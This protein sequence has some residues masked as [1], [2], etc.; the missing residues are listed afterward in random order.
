[1]R[2]GEIQRFLLVFALI[3]CASLPGS[4]QTQP[5]TSGNAAA[6]ANAQLLRK[7]LTNA[8]TAGTPLPTAT[9]VTDNLNIEAVMLPKS[10]SEHVFGKTVADH[11]AVI[12]VNIA[13]RSD[14]ASFVLQSLYIDYSKW[15]LGNLNQANPAGD[16]GHPYCK[17]STTTQ[18]SSVE[19]RI[20]R[21]QM[22]DRQPWSRRNVTS[23]AI[24]VL[25]SIGTAFAFPFTTDVVRGIGAWN[26]AV[27][28]GFDTLFPDGTQAHMDRVSDYGFRDNKVIPQQSADIVIAF[29][30]IDRF[31]TPTLRNIFLNSPALFFSPMLLALDPQS[32]KDVLKIM[33]MAFPK[34]ANR[35]TEKNLQNL[36][37]KIAALDPEAISADQDKVNKATAAFVQLQQTV[38]GDERSI[39]QSRD[40]AQLKDLTDKKSADETALNQAEK[41]MNDADQALSKDFS[42][43]ESDPVYRFLE[44]MSLNNISI[45]VSGIMSVDQ[46]IIPATINSTCF[47]KAGAELWGKKQEKKAC[48]IKG[49]YL[50][51]GTPQIANGSNLGITNLTV[52]KT[53][54][55]AELLNFT[56]DLKAPLT[57]GDFD[58]VVAKT[59]KNGTE[60]DS[61]KYHVTIDY[62]AAAA[63]A[64][65]KIDQSGTTITVTGTDFGSSDSPP[66]V[67]LRPVGGATPDKTVTTKSAD[68]ATITLDASKFT[69]VADG[70]YQLAIQAGGN[71]VVSDTKLPAIRV[72]TPKV[73]SA[74]PNAGKV[75]IAGSELCGSD[76]KFELLDATA[77]S[78][79]EIGPPP[80]SDGTKIDLDPGQAKLADAKGVLIDKSFDSAT[81]EV[82][83]PDPQGHASATRG[84]AKPRTNP[85]APRGKQAH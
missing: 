58:L 2:P 59:A 42:I 25:G 78:L 40:S 24:R 41:E 5:S 74:K 21:G 1:M 81:K 46:D 38:D 48:F 66:Q 79:G 49:K 23:R 4:S 62:K 55:T 39:G 11:Y 6:E 16:C 34:T 36:L 10:I 69:G 67:S 28:P 3:C 29:F 18:V 35:D 57:K 22:L 19:Y 73:D 50:T 52:D 64:I 31:L 72:G 12:E 75:E 61:T 84:A 43:L 56:F 7:S 44:G 83:F 60:I 51:G 70:C 30:P 8:V 65:S 82:K 20:V 9:N 68:S 26:G 85:A 76:L 13:N 77:K 54:S 80:A 63:P 14:Q 33:K 15:L 45:V 17:A 53:G 71:A 37:T 32:N 47:D 27:A